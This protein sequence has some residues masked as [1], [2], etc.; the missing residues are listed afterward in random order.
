MWKNEFVSNVLFEFDIS[1]SFFKLLYPFKQFP[2]IICIP[3]FYSKIQSSVVLAPFVGF[4][5]I[6]R[7]FLF[8]FQVH[9]VFLKFYVFRSN[10]LH[11]LYFL[12]TNSKPTEFA[13]Y[14]C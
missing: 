5:L 6:R 9:F 10:L 1:E 7:V 2:L 12:N 4:W 11:K 14:M 8:Y 13:E 3:F